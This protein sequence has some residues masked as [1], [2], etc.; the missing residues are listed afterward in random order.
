M[1]RAG[2]R[3]VSRSGDV[4]RNAGAGRGS[5]ASCHH[6]CPQWEGWPLI[7]IFNDV[8]GDRRPDLYGPVVASDQR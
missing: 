6:I 7:G 5:L 8:L 4:R 1:A 3:P 2:R